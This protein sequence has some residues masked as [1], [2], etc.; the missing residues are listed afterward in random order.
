MRCKSIFFVGCWAGVFSYYIRYKSCAA[1]IVWQWT[2]K[3]RLRPSVGVFSVQM[4]SYT[5]IDN[6][7]KQ[8]LRTGRIRYFL[9]P[10]YVWTTAQALLKLPYRLHVWLSPCVGGG[11]CH[12]VKDRS[13]A[14]VGVGVG[15]QVLVLSCGQ[16]DMV[17][18]VGVGVGVGR[19][20]G[21]WPFLPS[22]SEGRSVGGRWRA[23]LYNGNFVVN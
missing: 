10:V 5:Q 18:G 16:V 14:G 23:G 20:G 11:C 6:N 12:G 22:L 21:L 19:W 4:W 9:M 17:Q 8:R 15:G 2:K 13:R 1:L 7:G 3:S